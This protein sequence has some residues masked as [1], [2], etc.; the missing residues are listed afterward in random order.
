MFDFRRVVSKKLLSRLSLPAA[1]CLIALLA[2]PGYGAAPAPDSIFH[3]TA[4]QF[5]EPFLATASTTA[6]DDAALRQAIERY[7]G[8]AVEDDFSPMTGYLGASKTSG[9]R[10][11]VLTNLGLSYYHD[12]YFS[13]AIDSWEQA[14]REGKEAEDPRAK[15]IV[16]RAVGELLRMHARLGHADRIES[17][18]KE[19]G[20]RPLSGPA[21]EALTGA[22]EGLWMM[23]NEPGEAYLC[24][25]MALKNLLILEGAKPDKL[26]SLEHY[27]SGPQGVSLEQ[28]GTLA[29]QAELPHRLVFR[30]SGQAIPV[31]SIVHWK[32]SHFAAII[33]QEGDRFHV[34]DPTFGRDLWIS[35]RALESEAS[36]YFL[37][38]S[39]SQE[40]SLV[41]RPVGN[42]EASQVRGMG[43]TSFQ[44][45]GANLLSELKKFFGT[46]SSGMCVADTTM[47][48]VGVHLEDTPVGYSPPKGPDAHI[49]VVYNQREDSQ[50]ATFGW[51]N[52]SPKWTLTALAYIQDDPT[53]PGANVM[54]YAAGGGSVAYAGYVTA[55][56]AFTPETRDASVLVRTS[57]SP[58]TY[59]RRLQDGSKEVYAQSNG[60]TSYPRRVFLTQMVDRFGNAS[61]YAYDAQL[62]LTSITDATG[63]QTTFSYE[64]TA[65]PLLVTRITDPFGRSAVLAYDANN[66]LSK[67][68]DVLGLVSQFTYDASGL[69]NALTTPYGTTSFA[70]GDNGTTRFV[71]TTDPLGYTDRVE[72]H[73][74]APGV[75]YSDP[76]NTV[77][78]G[79]GLCNCY[80]YYRDSYYWDKHMYPLA[81]G[82]YNQARITHFH[83]WITNSNE[84]AHSV[85]SIKLPLENR[86]SF[87]YPGQVDGS[88]YSG[89]YDRPT[90]IARVLDDGTSQETKLTYNAQ[91]N[92]TDSI[93]PAGRETQFAYAANGI[94]VTSVKQKTSASGYSTLATM[95]YNGQH[96]PLTMT[97]A[98]GQTTT[99]TYNNAGQPLT[100]TDALGHVST[101]NY[102]GQG[103]LTSVVNANN[104]TQ[105][106]FTYDGFGRVGSSTDSEGRTVAYQYDALDRPT[107]ET[108]P[109]GTTRQNAY[110]RLDLASVTDRQGRTTTFSY[111]ANRQITQITDP[112]QRKTKFAYYENGVRKNLTDPNG[113]TT[114]WTIDLESRVTGKTYADGKGST[115]AYE[116]TTSRLKSVTDALGQKKQYSYTIDNRLAGIAYT[117]AVNSTPN[118]S[119]KY[120]PYF[121]RPVSMTDGTGATAYTYQPIG[122]L[123][124]LQLAQADGPYNNDVIGYAYDALGRPVTRTVGGSPETFGYDAI[125]RPTTEG[126]ALGTFNLGYLGQTGQL[127]SQL[128]QGGAVGTSWT[129]DTNENDRRLKAIT[130][131]G[132]TR[133][134]Q[135]TTT[136]ESDITQISEIAGAGSAF[137]SQTW[138]YS[139][140]DS[141]RLTAATSSLGKAYG[142]GYDA[143]DNITSQQ[144]PS[145]SS[146]LSYNSLNQIAGNSYDANGNLLDD[147]Q[148]TYTW[149]AENRLLSVTLKTQAGKVTT[150]RYDGYGRRIAIITNGTEV[151]YLWCG[152]QLCQA[153]SA[154]DVV[155][156]RYFA[157][158]EVIPASGTAL[159]YME[160]Q[161]GSVRD[162]VAVQNG[163][164]VASYDYEPYGSPSQTAGRIGTDFRFAHLFYEPNSG[165]YL[166]NTRAY[167][168]RTGHWIS[169]DHLEEFG[170]T[171]LYSYVNGQ[172]LTAIDPLGLC[173][174]RQQQRELEGAAL[175]GA[176][177]AVAIASDGLAG[178]LAEALAAAGLADLDGAA[179]I[180][181]AAALTQGGLSATAVAQATVV[182]IQAGSAI[183]AGEGISMMTQSGEAT[184]G[185]ENTGDQGAEPQG[186][187]EV[188]PS[189]LEKLNN[190]GLSP[191][192]ANEIIDDPST[193]RFVDNAN[194]GNINYIQDMNGR[195]TRITTDP[196]GQRIISAGQVR[197]NQIING[198][199]KGRFTRF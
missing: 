9:W 183:V 145:G 99:Y 38:P 77:P 46:C 142:Y 104:Q 50:P 113:N 4:S 197:L 67:I 79:L 187:R 84:T 45:F 138:S 69:I 179:V 191:E 78:T 21:T 76:A 52:V 56:G 114:S 150:F 72:F 88:Y 126:N 177:V 27:R 147:G 7:R 6:Q 86:I 170:G 178:P 196:T 33:G 186:N 31:P 199:G 34:S 110:N 139:V 63:R 188:V 146:S 181:G 140:D 71:N 3:L 116:A 14:W 10:V 130:N 129:Y 111:D 41:W 59:E 12:G 42:T 112:L 32:V 134:Y 154:A 132:A 8:R 83:H 73:H 148:R 64:L 25:P 156:R 44:Q 123:G 61:T 120:D 193:A 162:A 92:V 175:V 167:D 5:E 47:L 128:L 36:G 74:Q 98:A 24:G 54:R 13:K 109:D 105:A 163:A 144:T 97:D 166:S 141:S 174:T 161:I 190:L 119:W 30:Q 18:L 118:V 180:G 152:Q 189:A 51:F 159:Y 82:N 127:T 158:G 16:D 60:A 121:V 184:G 194:D 100:K 133:S 102:D 164:R 165:L 185:T 15:P 2:L 28:V 91:G 151:R 131:S 136:P 153:R 195:L 108:Y 26:A 95:T 117:N 137:P 17:L 65:Q 43:F 176:A 171:N 35:R 169:R 124:A 68:T 40:A 198:L 37:V 93:D 192:Q 48:T 155:T 58:L 80:L 135:L 75:A 62:R 172:V 55:T 22:K 143:A 20:D 182:G 87:T 49:K 70:Y 96:L 157:E 57:A 23:R 101:F 122:A 66:R 106:S 85:E 89:S 39:P 125:N 19:I 94:D 90:A 1:L 160:D 149:D 103:Y 29:A 173:L 81:G 11:A 115:D 107:I 168:P 53:S